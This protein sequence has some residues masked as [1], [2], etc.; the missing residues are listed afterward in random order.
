MILDEVDDKSRLEALASAGA[1]MFSN[2]D[3]RKLLEPPLQVERHIYPS[4]QARRLRYRALLGR[5]RRI[6]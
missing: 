4:V 2:H 5:Y 3:G 6:H 1:S